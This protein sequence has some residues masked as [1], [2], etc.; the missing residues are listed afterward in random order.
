MVSVV[1]IV[2][3]LLWHHV[4]D[5]GNEADHS[6]KHHH[7]DE[8]VQCAHCT[9]GAVTSSQVTNVHVVQ[10]V[11]AGFRFCGGVWM[12]AMR[13]DEKRWLFWARAG[14]TLVWRLLPELELLLRLLLERR[15]C[16]VCHRKSSR[17]EC[18][19][20]SLPKP[21]GEQLKELESMQRSD[22]SSVW[23]PDKTSLSIRYRATNSASLNWLIRIVM[24]DMDSLVLI[25]E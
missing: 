13:R 2:V 8:M 23:T 5:D 10:M 15:W 19:D 25:Q 12:N 4:R 14:R 16:C 6:R 24:N 7:R 17:P 1:I 21:A 11:P 20:K 3:V 18:A 9:G 22:P